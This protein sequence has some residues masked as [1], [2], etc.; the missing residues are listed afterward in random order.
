MRIVPATRHFERAAITLLAMGSLWLGTLIYHNHLGGHGSSPGPSSPASSPTMVIGVGMDGQPKATELDSITLLF[1][2]SSDCRYCEQTMAAWKRLAAA[3][4]NADTIEANVLVLSTSS[5][6]DTSSYLQRH[7]LDAR[8]LLIE[9][10]ELAAL[11][12]RGVPA[13]LIV[14]PAPQAPRLWLGPLDEAEEAAI[15]TTYR[16]WLPELAASPESTFR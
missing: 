10:T 16:A 3:L 14:G 1:V 7:G 8:W 5:A 13:T 6:E 11:G 12:A 15:L 2:L 9:N 4:T